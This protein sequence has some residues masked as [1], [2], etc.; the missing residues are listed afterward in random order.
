MELESDGIDDFV[1]RSG[2]FDVKYNVMDYINYPKTNWELNAINQNITQRLLK[3]SW[4]KLYDSS[5]LANQMEKMLNGIAENKYESISYAPSTNDSQ[6]KAIQKALG[7]TYFSVIQGPPGTGKT[8]TIAKLCQRLLEQGMKVFVTGPTHTAINNCLVAIS[9]DVKDNSK[10]VKIG[11]KYQATEILGNPYITRKTRLNY[12]SYED[13]P[14][15]SH[16]GIVVGGTPYALCFPASKKMEGWQFDFVIIDEAA[17]VSMPLAL[18]AM[19]Y[20]KKLVFVGDHMQLDPIIPKNT[21]NWL[22]GS[23]IFKRMVDLYPDQVV[24]LNQSYRLNQHLIRVPNQLFYSGKINSCCPVNDKYRF[25]DCK[26]LPELIRHPSNE[27]LVVHHDFG[28]LGRSPFEAEMISDMIS[29]LLRNGVPL[30]DIGVISPYRAQIRE[31]KRALVEKN[32][33]TIES[34]DQL[35]ID[36]VER[37]Q[38]QE[39]DYIFFS[40]A[41]C[42]PEEVENRLEFFYSPNRLNV[43]ITRA[44]IKCITLTNEKIF[45]ICEERLNNQNNSDELNKGMQ[46][47]INFER[48]STKVEVKDTQMDFNSFEL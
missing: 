24:L 47:F 43:A 3:A 25:F 9:K 8:Y 13:N 37:M 40:M 2:D 23:S 42:N 46:A 12:F 35:F 7:C 20:G 1:L 39:K 36:T 22:F 6:N 17:Q 32:V 14:N 5:D 26:H 10:I 16:S 18:A 30:E 31:V 28:A 45:K 15:L 33:V 21:N 27:L 34:L 11:E 48:L 41:N 4:Q 44:H 38:G 29:D 19:P